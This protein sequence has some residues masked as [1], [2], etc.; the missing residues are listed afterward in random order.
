MIVQ[1]RGRTMSGVEQGGKRR[2]IIWFV[3]KRAEVGGQ[4]LSINGERQLSGLQCTIKSGGNGRIEDVQVKGT[5]AGS[6]VERRMDE[7]D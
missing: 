6:I 4:R 1:K 3:E 2:K 7:Q 5:E